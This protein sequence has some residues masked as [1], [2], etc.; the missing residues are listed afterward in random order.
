MKLIFGLIFRYHMTNNPFSRQGFRSKEIKSEPSNSNI[1]LISKFEIGDAM[2]CNDIYAPLLSS[3]EL[4]YIYA[5]QSLICSLGTVQN[6]YLIKQ[7]INT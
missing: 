5:N 3:N 1:S 2:Y 7:L 4:Y 6:K